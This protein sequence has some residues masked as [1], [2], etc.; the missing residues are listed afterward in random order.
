LLPFSS[1]SLV[2]PPP[3]QIHKTIISPVVSFG[4]ET[5]SLTLKKEHRLRV[6]ENRVLRR[7]AEECRRLHNEELGN[8]YA[9]PNIVKVIMSRRMRWAGHIART[10]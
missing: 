7:V 10:G 2:F 6:F 9:S 5:W 4:C 1:E 3:L 8:L